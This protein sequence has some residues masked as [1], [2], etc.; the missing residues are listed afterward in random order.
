MKKLAFAIS[1]ILV[2]FMTFGLVSAVFAVARTPD[3]KIHI[4]LAAD[5][6][7]QALQD[8]TIDLND[9]PLTKDWVDTWALM[10]STITLDDYTELGMMEIDINNQM[11]PTGDDT[12]K[13]YKL[14]SSKSVK[15]V[16]FR[17]A[18]A[19]LLDRD[20]IVTDVLKGYG[21]RMDVPL[22]PFQ[23][24]YKDDYNYSTSGVIYNFNKTRA[25]NIL[26]AAGFTKLGSGLRQDPLTPG[27]ALAPIT[28]Y[29]RQDDSNRRT[30][31]EMLTG[32][33]IAEGIPVNAIITERTVC[34]KNVMV[35]YNYHLYT[36]GWSLTSIPDAYYDLYSS[37]TYYGPSIGWSQNYPGFCNNG[38]LFGPLPSS[39]ADAEGFDYWA[40]KVKYPDTVADAITSAQT[41]GYLF[42]KYCAMVPMY[43][44]K[45]VKAYRTYSTYEWK[46]VVNNAGFGIDNYW[47]FLNMHQVGS[48]GD[49]RIDWAFKSD[50][51]QLNQVSSEWLWD[52]NVLGLMYES[53]VGANPFDLS[54]S[55]F[56]L[57][58]AGFVGTFTYGGAPATFINFTL[59]NNVYWHNKTGEPRRLFKASDVNFSFAY[60][61]ACGPGIAWSYP[62]LKEWLNCTIYD[63]THVAV[64]YKKKSAWAYQ[65][66]G[67]LPMINPDTWSLVGPGAD[68]KTYDPAKTDLN[69]DGIF[70][71]FEDGTG[72]WIYED[73]NAGNWVTL[74]ADP[75][76]YLT[77]TFISDRLAAMFHSGAGDINKE[78]V[79][80]ILDLSMLAR[81]LGANPSN[82]GTGWNQ[83]NID[84]D[85]DLN[86]IVDIRELTTVT[87]NYGKTMG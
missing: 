5:P 12:S 24:A 63:D 47:T 50:I 52:Q 35:L 41:A 38:T 54:P 53:L 17:K 70:D 61:Y 33:L 18:V 86:G 82:P 1:V 13:F 8:G 49:A 84:C 14:S 4:Y 78:G 58:N 72:A 34:Y 74:K 71:L 42:L 68:T 9:W 19:C 83:Y 22:P 23:S 7:N 57:A 62:S 11:W 37:F 20:A 32:E 16:E 31:G 10:P 44:S 80:N 39:H 55:E 46:G 56:F 26:D 66:A 64:F 60:Q 75:S 48:G 21:Y 85:L 28:F 73:Y 51:E 29:I 2:A 45:A 3:L 40:M 65:W 77:D 25:E 79:V 27:V 69:G 43:C 59:R 76:Y 67:G 36:G 6:E 81:S 87:S 30:A 15:S